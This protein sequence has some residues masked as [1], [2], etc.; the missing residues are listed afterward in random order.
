MIHEN[1]ERK[2]TMDRRCFLRHALGTLVGGLG[3]GG[4]AR[5][6]M[7]MGRASRID[8]AYLALRGAPENPRPGAIEQMLLEL[9]RNT[10]VEVKAQAPPIAPTAIDLYDHPMVALF[11]VDAPPPMAPDERRALERFLRAGGLLFIDDSSGLRKSPFDQW[12][13]HE[14]R[15][16]FPNT[17]LERISSRHVVFRSFF[18]TNRVTG[19]TQIS[20]F[21]EGITLD[22]EHTPVIYSRND[23]A[24]AFARDIAG[25][26][27]YECVPGGAVQRTAAYKLGINI[28][29]YALCL[30]YKLDLTHVRALLNRPRGV[31]DR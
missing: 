23:L 26:Y 1:N 13:R 28:L 9:A 12:V 19:R 22:A 21:L 29:M 11:G 7:A 10:S 20:R 3:M 15:T 18:L 31:S 27:R 25:G 24:G 5:P 30:N 4:F 14:L 2:V 6:L 8:V 16:I 17:P